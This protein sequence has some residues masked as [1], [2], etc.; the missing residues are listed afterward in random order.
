MTIWDAVLGKSVLGTR[1]SVS[2]S[3][4]QAYMPTPVAVAMAG[5]RWK[6]FILTLTVLK[7]KEQSQQSKYKLLFWADVE[8]LKQNRL[9]LPLSSRVG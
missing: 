2:V 9:F 7:N 1:L 6:C 8:K 5:A 3:L 4:W